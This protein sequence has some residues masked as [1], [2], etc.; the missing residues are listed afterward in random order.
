MLNMAVVTWDAHEIKK[1][2]SEAIPQIL[3]FKTHTIHNRTKQYRL[4]EI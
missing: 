2:S 3:I 4:M 1:E